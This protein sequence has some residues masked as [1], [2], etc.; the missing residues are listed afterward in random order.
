M[1]LACPWLVK[2]IVFILLI[3]LLLVVVVVVVVVDIARVIWVVRVWAR[4]T[5]LGRRGLVW[6]G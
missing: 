3:L 4:R 2:V 1:H 5:R 6:L